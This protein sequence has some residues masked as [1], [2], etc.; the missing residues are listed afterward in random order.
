VKH[1]EIRYEGK[2]RRSRD[3]SFKKKNS[4]TFFGYK[5]HTIVDDNIP[6]PAIRSYAV[7]TA[8]DHDNTLDMIQWE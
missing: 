4:K 3:G 2:T 5:G 1:D 6:V 7:S 8:K